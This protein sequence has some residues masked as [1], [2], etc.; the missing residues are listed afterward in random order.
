MWDPCDAFEKIILPNGLT[1]YAQEWPRR[2]FQ[3]MSFVVHSGSECDPQEKEGAAHF[4]EHM[5]N[6]NSRTSSDEMQAFFDE[7]GGR[8][9]FGA[10][11]FLDTKYYFFLPVETR[12]LASGLELFGSLLLTTPFEQNLERERAVIVGEFR[13][14]F[15]IPALT[16]NILEQYRRIFYAGTRFERMIT[17]L[18]SLHTIGTMNYGDL[19][20]FYERYYTPANISIVTV[21]GTPVNNIVRLIAES[22]FGSTKAGVRHPLP[23]PF[24]PLIPEE[25]SCTIDMR[26]HQQGATN[27][28]YGVLTALAAPK[29]HAAV[30]LA[31]E[32]LSHLLHENIREKY[33]WTYSIGSSM[34]YLGGA[35]DLDISCQSLAPEGVPFITEAVQACVTEASRREDLFERFRQRRIR[36]KALS[37]QSAAG[38]VKEATKDLG[39]RH[40]IISLA[41]EIRVLEETKMEDIRGVLEYLAPHRSWTLLATP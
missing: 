23:E 31:T 25:R 7:Q 19:H 12:V 30:P 38:V 35:Y 1:V 13:R 5:V 2:P 16:W 9:M 36:T 20:S 26:K 34:Q 4:V 24:S 29:N 22:V 32:L 6:A 40:R 3:S 11:G 18:G 14:A 27:A 37:D 17:P 10:T 41:E 28:Q 8:A 39:H 33:G 15:P 21:G